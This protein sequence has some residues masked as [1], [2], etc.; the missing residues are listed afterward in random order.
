MAVS[1]I[2][3]DEKIIRAEWREERLRDSE[4][5]LAQD[6]AELGMVKREA[7]RVYRESLEPRTSATEQRS[8]T[9][10]GQNGGSETD[11]DSRTETS[12]SPNLKALELVTKCLERRQKLLGYGEEEQAKKRDK[13]R[14]FAFTVK[15]GDKVLASE[16]SGLEDDVVLD[17]EDAEFYEVGSDGKKLLTSGD[18]N[19]G[20]VQ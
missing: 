14:V 13:A 9:T 2:V 18:E 11:T 15:I 8:V 4:A 7:W 19:G 16:A 17:A 6:L 12:P 5:L 10:G 3:R 1:T 20:D